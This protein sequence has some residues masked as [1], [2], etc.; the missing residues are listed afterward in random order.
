VL[1]MMPC[2]VAL[3]D[4][5]GCTK[6]ACVRR[7]THESMCSVTCKTLRQG[8]RS[9]GVTGALKFRNGRVLG[10]VSSTQLGEIPSSYL[11]E[12][13]LAGGLVCRDGGGKELWS[14]NVRSQ[15]HQYKSSSTKI[16]ANSTSS[17][18]NFGE[19]LMRFLVRHLCR[20]ARC[21]Q[22]VARFRQCPTWGC[23]RIRDWDESRL[24]HVQAATRREVMLYSCPSRCSRVPRP[25][26]GR[27]S[28]CGDPT[29]SCLSGPGAR[30]G[31]LEGRKPVQRPASMVS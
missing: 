7:V 6:E 11:T 5:T 29:V 15:V 22:A 21:R 17:L 31:R 12:R 2:R 16:P 14:R 28:K 20:Q 26:Q 13:V 18:R 4:P 30:E 23:A 24:R 25:L 9:G 27:P 10:T 1:Y 19:A 8:N 3:C